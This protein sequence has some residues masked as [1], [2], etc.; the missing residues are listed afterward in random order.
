MKINDKNH[1]VNNDNID[2]IDNN[3]NND[4]NN[5]NFLFRSRFDVIFNFN[6]VLV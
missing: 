5:N 4:Y 6:L 2:D 3:D 1:N